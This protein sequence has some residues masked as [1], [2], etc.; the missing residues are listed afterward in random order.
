L[1]TL[2]IVADLL[3]GLLWTAPELLRMNKRP[4]KGTQKGDIYSYGVILQEVI[5]RRPAFYYNMEYSENSPKGHLSLLFFTFNT[6]EYF[7]PLYH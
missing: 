3:L 2:F 1:K 5:C 6:R 7:L 4:A